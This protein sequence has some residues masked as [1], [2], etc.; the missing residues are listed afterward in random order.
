GA[1]A[2]NKRLFFKLLAIVKHSRDSFLCRCQTL[3]GCF[4]NLLDRLAERVARSSDL[5]LKVS[6]TGGLNLNNLSIGLFCHKLCSLSYMS[7]FSHSLSRSNSVTVFA[8]RIPCLAIRF[9]A[10]NMRAAPTTK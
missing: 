7:F 6:L 2:P 4:L 1:Q 3:P 9:L 8:G 10:F 5:T